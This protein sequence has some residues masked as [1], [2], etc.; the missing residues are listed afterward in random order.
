[1]SRSATP[2]ADTD[3]G[4]SISLNPFVRIGPDESV[5]LV[6]N[7]SEMGQG[8]YTALPMLVAEELECDWTKIRVVAAPV[9]PAYNH[10]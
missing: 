1:M 3:G 5:T 10:T 9:D 2:N 6:V 4:A 8:V 7:H